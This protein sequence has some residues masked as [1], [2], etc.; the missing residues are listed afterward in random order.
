[1]YD[2]DKLLNF[3]FCSK[4]KKALQNTFFLE[5]NYREKKKMI[6]AYYRLLFFYWHCPLMQWP[7]PP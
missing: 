4:K 3:C 6:R 2:E 5:G 1:M 7:G